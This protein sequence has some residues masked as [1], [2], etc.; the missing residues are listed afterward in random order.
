MVAP[1]VGLLLK[2]VPNGLVVLG[3]HWHE[4]VALHVFVSPNSFVYFPFDNPGT[5]NSIDFCRAIEKVKMNQFTKLTK[6]NR[7]NV[8]KVHILDTKKKKE[9]KYGI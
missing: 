8:M 4:G 7:T 1:S 3:E 5:R 9:K 6:I 2:I